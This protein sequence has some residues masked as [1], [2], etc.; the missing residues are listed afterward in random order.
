[1]ECCAFS[2]RELYHLDH[3]AFIAFQN[4]NMCCVHS[5]TA[6]SQVSPLPAAAG[7]LANLLCLA[8]CGTIDPC[9]VKPAGQPGRF[10]RA[11]LVAKPIQKDSQPLVGLWQDDKFCAHRLACHIPLSDNT[12]YCLLTHTTS[13]LVS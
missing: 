7:T 5:M 10:E 13:T 11:Q 2:A 6:S 4:K 8:L 1:V 3:N 12:T 9:I